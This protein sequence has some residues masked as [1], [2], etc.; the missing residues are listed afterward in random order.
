MT[1][2]VPQVLQ[3]RCFKS[4]RPEPGRHLRILA[5]MTLFVA[6]AA[7]SAAQDSPYGGSARPIPGGIQAEDFNDGGQGVAYYDHSSG[8]NGGQYRTTDV[9][10][11]RTTTGGYA[12]GWIGAGEWLRYTVN[13]T[14]AGNYAIV[15][16][17]ASA[18]TGGTFH[19][20]FNGQDKTGSLRV[21]DTGGWSTYQDLPVVV[22]L[23][24]GV[25]TMRV[26]FDTD[27]ASTGAVGNISFFSFEPSSTGAPAV[28]SGGGG[29]GAS[30]FGGSA[31]TI[32]GT[33]QAED[34]D[35]GGEGVGYHDDSTG[36]SG[37]AYRSTNVDIATMSGGGH[38]VG[39]IG[40][41]EWLRYTVNVTAA[42]TYTM[43]ARVAS[44][45]SGGTFHIRFNGQNKTG[46]ISIP[47]TGAW[48][49][50]QE[51]T[52]SVTLSAGVQGMQIVFDSNGSTGA[53]GNLSSVRFDAGGGGGSGSSGMH[54]LRRN[55]P[56][57]SGLH[58]GRRLR[59][60]RRGRRLPRCHVGQYR[61]RL[62]LDRRRHQDNVL[63]RLRD[64]L[65]RS[66]RMAEIQRERQLGG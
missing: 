16:R 43:V 53:V 6:T 62:S 60:G 48:G 27:G 59:S 2:R 56:G 10:I 30:P 5:A 58:S 33:V 38:T 39:W 26:V 52:A 11:A 18:G 21:P 31:W 9:D 32:P 57:D 63:G 25:Q 1:R 44:A 55:G 51:V 49:S 37:G 3:T 14:S 8:N 46:S 4:R 66:R 22:S 47:N 24:Q 20:E 54:T 34:F 41:G 15:A 40:A 61:E 35:Q 17:V 50:Y 29:G 36:N 42:G 19:I 45:G 23:S 12:V 28:G 64:R 65:D 13:V 7:V